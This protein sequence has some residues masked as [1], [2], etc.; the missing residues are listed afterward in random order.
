MQGY[1]KRPEE[2]AVAL[3]E[4]WMHTGDIARLDDE[5]FYFIV[6]RAKDMIISGG[7]NI[8]TTEVENALYEH[9]AVL[10]AAVI[11]IPDERWGEAVHAVVVAAAGPEGDGGGA[12]RVLPHEDRG[13]Q[14]PQVGDG[15]VGAAAEVGAGEDPE[16]GAAQAV[17]G[18]PGGGRALGGRRRLALRRIVGGARLVDGGLAVREIA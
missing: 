3:R 18:G 14:V 8:F 12:D 15:V 13:L 5:G 10:E 2:T 11:G 4:G 17:L 7:E 1:W 16:D 6:D 9:P